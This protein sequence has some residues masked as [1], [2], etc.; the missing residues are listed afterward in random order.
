MTATADHILFSGRLWDGSPSDDE[1]LAVADGRV[2]ARGSNREISALQGSGTRTI[3]VGGRRVVPGL[4]DSH[5]H[6]VRAGRTWDSEV[7]WDDASGL[8]EALH[9]IRARAEQ[10]GPGHWIAVMGGWHPH[11]FEEDRPP[12]REDLDRAAPDNPVF[13]QRAY[14]ESFTNTLA[15]REM[16]WDDGG[17]G[18][19]VSPADMADLRARVAVTDV[20]EAMAGTHSLLREL[21]RL[22]LTGAIDASGF[23]ITAKSYDA[24]FRLFAEG[25]RGFRARLLVGAS[26][27]GMERE[28]MEAWTSKVSPGDG[29]DFVRYL[30]AGEVLDYAAHDLEGLAPKDIAERAGALQEISSLLAGRGWP[31]HL[32]SILDSSLDTVLSAWEEVDADLAALRFGICHA[33]QIGEENLRRVRDL[34]VGITIQNGMSMRGVDCTPTWGDERVAVSP[35]LRSMLDLGIPVAAGTD[36]TVACAYD[37]WRCI[38]WMVTGESIDGAPPRR[39]DQRLTRDEA[40]RLYTSAGAWFTFEEETRGNLRPGS[41]ADLAV[42]SNDPLTVAEEALS[43]IESVLTVVGGEIAHATIETG[44][45]GS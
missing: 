21:N 44:D 45:Q 3:D 30:G 10:L 1:A 17:D 28:D 24:F 34:G 12:G 13:V 36:G 19:I 11:Q 32:H 41:H 37:P 38:A 6:L 26:R 16:G 14:A 2:L 27:P 40:L 29:D 15:T 20:D 25:E 5:I 9:L 23:G 35:P 22:G 39:K 8:E 7:R 43:S 31:V 33:D 42:L 4:I 18:K